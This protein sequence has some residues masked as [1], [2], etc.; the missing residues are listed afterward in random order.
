MDA[1]AGPTSG[2]SATRIPAARAPPL[3]TPP[4]LLGPLLGPAAAPCAQPAAPQPPPPL[5]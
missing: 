3:P 4:R 5:C 2:F 1:P